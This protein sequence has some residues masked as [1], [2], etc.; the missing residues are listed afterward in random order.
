MT[1]ITQDRIAP[2]FRITANDSDIT[3][4]IRSRFKWL[5]ITDESG[6]QSDLLEIGLADHDPTQPLKIPRTGAELRVWLGYDGKPTTDKGLFVVDEIELQGPPDEMVI[7]ARAAVY[8]QT[9]LGKTD[10]Q[11]Q[12]VRDWPN[13][14][15]LG[16]MVQKIAREHDMQSV[17]ADSIASITL[18]HLAQTSE[19]D[20]SFLI[21]VLK[22]YDL[23]VKPQAG[24]L[25]VAKRGESKR[26]N[27]E[28]M[29]AVTVD[30]SQTSHH[31]MTKARRERP[32]TVVAFFHDTRAAKRV[33]VSVGSGDPVKQ[34]RHFFPTQDAA[35]AAA[36]AALDKRERG[37]HRLSFSMVGD[38]DLTA[39]RPLTVT[40]FRDGINGDWLIRR[41]EHHID[42]SGYRCDVEAELPNG[43]AD[44]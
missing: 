20:I 39:E 27:G 29:P 10:L 4:A 44:D 34:I 37:E 3:S 21:R 30:R 14:T 19:S 43:T 9:K 7:R 31:S 32:G 41:V 26:P 1:F 35:L 24:K 36:Q 8:D 22:N 25:I 6:L 15:K 12:K 13:G 38:P 40:G 33:E 11:T 16:A 5:R 2:A 23:V 17:V 18:P 42:S 28:A